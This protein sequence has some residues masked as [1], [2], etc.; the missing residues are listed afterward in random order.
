MGLRGYGHTD[1]GPHVQ[2]ADKLGSKAYGFGSGSLR[3]K[4]AASGLGF[5][6]FPWGEVRCMVL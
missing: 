4:I 2:G 5:S 1:I 6:F 3:L